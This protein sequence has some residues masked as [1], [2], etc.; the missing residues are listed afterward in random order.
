MEHRLMTVP[1]QV[2]VA[3]E[4]NRLREAGRTIEA[5]ALD[6]S[7]PIPA[8]L[9]KVF[10]EK[11]GADFLIEGGWNLAEAEAAFGSDWLTR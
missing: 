11:V 3:R 9:A 4:A 10:K 2:A 1:E 8:Y 5:I 6:R 7:I